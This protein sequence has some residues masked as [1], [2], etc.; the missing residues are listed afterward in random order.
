MQ[1]VYIFDGC[2]QSEIEPN[3]P[4][5]S[6]KSMQLFVKTFRKIDRSVFMVSSDEEKTGLRSLK[7]YLFL[8]LRHIGL[9]YH[10]SS[11]IV[12]LN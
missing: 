1:T 10:C 8:L 3:V 12:I 5:M 2:F 6:K 4:F 11:G 7:D 9:K